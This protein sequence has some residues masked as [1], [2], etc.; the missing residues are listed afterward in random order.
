MIGGFAG[1][2]VTKASRTSLSFRLHIKD[3][4]VDVNAKHL[5]TVAGRVADN[6]GFDREDKI[7]HLFGFTFVMHINSKGT[8]GR[9]KARLLVGRHIEMKL[10]KS[11]WSPAVFF[12]IFTDLN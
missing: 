6:A 10:W 1:S 7:T 5:S 3:R 11:W 4:Y 9:V 2:F 8:V 12:F